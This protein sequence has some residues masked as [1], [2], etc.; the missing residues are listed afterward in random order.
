MASQ[1]RFCAASWNGR[2]R[3]PVSL[4][5]RKILLDP[6][7]AA[8]A[9]FEVGELAAGSAGGGVCPQDQLW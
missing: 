3:S 7:V 9:Q 1:I 5:L 6:G 4:P 8:V 2:L